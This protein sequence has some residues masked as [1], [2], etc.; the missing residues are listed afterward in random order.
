MNVEDMI[1]CVKRDCVAFVFYDFET[2]QDETLE[3]TENV[4]IHVLILCVAQQICKVCAG[5]EVMS[6]RC[7]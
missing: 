7:R 3:G 5:I 1:E 4:R 2:R 6:L